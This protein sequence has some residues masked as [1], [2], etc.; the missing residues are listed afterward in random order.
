MSFAWSPLV[1]FYPCLVGLLSREI[2]FSPSDWNGGIV[3]STSSTGL[4]SSQERS[5]P[6]KA[7]VTGMRVQVAVCAR[8]CW[9]V[10]GGACEGRAGV[11][12]W[13]GNQMGPVAEGGR[14]Q[15]GDPGRSEPRRR[16]DVCQGSV[17]L[18]IGVLPLVLLAAFFQIT[19]N[20]VK[21]LETF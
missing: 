17:P 5:L 11:W 15:E 12:W 10:L 14:G 4:D 20:L 18:A 19:L 3:T 8:W 13:D 2:T 6:E 9:V 21:R 16:L 1:C 7:Q